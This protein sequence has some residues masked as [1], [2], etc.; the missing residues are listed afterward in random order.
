VAVSA[1]AEQ[2]KAGE[3]NA[4]PAKPPYTKLAEMHMATLIEKGTDRYGRKHLPIWV[5]N[6]DLDTLNTFMRF[7]DGLEQVYEE[8][9]SRGLLN[10]SSWA[11]WGIGHRVIRISQRPAGCSNLFVDQ[12]TIRAATLMDLLSGKNAYGPAIEAYIKHYLKHFID[13]RNGLLRWGIHVSYDVFYERFNCEDGDYHEVQVILPVWPVMYDVEPKTMQSYLEKFW[14]WHTDSKTGQVDRHNSRG[15]GLGFA[16]AAGEVVLVCGYLHTKQPDGPW[17]DRAIQVAKA[18][19]DARDR[20]TNLF[21]NRA[22]GN[23]KRFD[24]LTGDTSIPGCWS[25]RVLMAGRLT[26]SKELTEIARQS[27]LAWSRY[28]WDEK[29]RKPWSMLNPDGT[30]VDKKRLKGT[31]YDKQAAFGHW[32]FWKDY[33]Y[34]FES[35]FQTLMSYVM[36]AKWTG[37]AELLDHAKRLAECYRAL[38]PANGDKGTF[39]ANYGRLISF[40]LIMESLTRDSAY[41]D[42]AKRVADEAVR[43]LWAGRMFRG[44]RDRTYYA[45]IEGQGQLIQGLVELEADPKRLAELR[46]KHPFLW[47][48]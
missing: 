32:N 40:L 25:S 5:L 17:L 18:H 44:F 37:D 42:T 19:W 7:D 35:P 27:L 15:R 21:A 38:L 43:H 10:Y 16:M 36:A 31:S 34:G 24:R 9:M 30:P 8:R 33:V 14:Y 47:N 48:F 22:Y 1:R 2:K 45:A 13:P 46:D 29:A 6:L 11:P 26:G 20:K 28:G 39:A 4:L 12:P 23:D 3:M 41:R